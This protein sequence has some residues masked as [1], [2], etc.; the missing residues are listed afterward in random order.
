MQLLRDNLTLWTSDIPEDG[1]NFLDFSQKEWFYYI[2]LLNVTFSYSNS[3]VRSILC[4]SYF[5][6]L[7]L[8][9]WTL[10]SSGMTP[11]CLCN[12]VYNL[13]NTL[14]VTIQLY[15]LLLYMFCKNH[16][17][18]SFW[19]GSE[20]KVTWNYIKHSRWKIG[21]RFWYGSVIRMQLMLEK[22]QMTFVKLELVI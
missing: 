12:M 21:S 8:V 11:F 22:R 18:E 2:F 3:Y 6:N 13:Y 17:V 19:N 4:V 1:G 9:L 14:P 15:W 16:L 20:I 7:K 10:I 5:C